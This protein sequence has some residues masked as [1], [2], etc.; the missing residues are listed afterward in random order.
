MG[1]IPDYA[2]GEDA[3]GGMRIGGVMPDSAAEKAGLREGDV[4]TRFNGEQI[5]N[6][7]DYTAALGKGRPGQAVKLH[8]L[9]ESSQK[10]ETISVN[11]AIIDV[12]TVVGRSP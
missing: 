4:I 1:A 10:A 5:D 6:M 9:H 8:V 11:R 7:M 3:K 2:Q 12:P